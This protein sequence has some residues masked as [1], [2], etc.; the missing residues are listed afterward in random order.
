MLSRCI[1]PICSLSKTGL[2]LVSIALS[3]PLTAPAL[4]DSGPSQVLYIFPGVYDNGDAQFTGIATAVHCFSF[5][6]T[7]ETIQYTARNFNAALV[8]TTTYTIGKFETATAVTHPVSL[9]GSEVVLNTGPLTQGVIGI[10]ATS[11]NIVCTAHVIDASATVPNGIDLHGTR[12]NPI[13][14]S[15]E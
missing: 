11:A 4:A 5:S 2:L 3:A 12:F 14:G 10:A 7:P 15:Q 1:T 6:P 9:Y 8:T 13:S